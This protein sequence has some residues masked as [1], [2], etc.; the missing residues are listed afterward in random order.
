VWDVPVITDRT[1]LTNRPDIVLHDKKKKTC[2]LIY[3][4]IT[5]GSIFN[6]RGNRKQS[7]YKYLEIELSRIWKERTKFVP[8]IIG[9]LE[10]IKKGLDQNLQLH[11][12]HQSA[13][14]LHK[15]TLMSTAT[16]IRKVLE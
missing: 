9:A 7:K 2:L 14:D 13:V 3:G 5:V 10:T 6:I 1:I 11:P 4:T 12:G 16:I 15:I 8:V